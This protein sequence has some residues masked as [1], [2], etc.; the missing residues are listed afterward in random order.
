[1]LRW[2]RHAHWALRPWLDWL[3]QRSPVEPTPAWAFAR[4]PVTSPLSVLA[5]GAVI[6]LA[7][8]PDDESLG[9]GGLI[10]AC[11]AAG[12]DVHLVILTDGSA[13]H[14]DIAGWPPERIAALRATEVEAA[15]RE[16]GVK[17]SN[18]HLMG[19]ADGAV[20]HRGGAFLQ[21]AGQLAELVRS[22]G[23][24]TLLTTWLHDGH[25]DHAA[26]ALLAEAVSALQPVRHLSYPIWGWRLSDLPQPVRGWRIDIAPHRAAKRRAIA[27]HVSQ[28]TDLIAGNAGWGNLS[29]GFRTNFDRDYE[30]ILQA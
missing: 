15:A 26:S 21:M 18:L 5:E 12:R 28:T 22:T 3:L 13:S 6:V 23:A 29:P 16:L 25:R 1:M 14:R 9:C 8:H 20:A 10:A 19:A 24:G 17:P 4:L 2:L 30:V 7:P 11:V 27:A